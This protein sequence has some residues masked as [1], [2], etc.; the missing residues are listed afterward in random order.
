MGTNASPSV[1]F[2][3]RADTTSAPQEFPLYTAAVAAGFPSAADDYVQER[4]DLNRALIQHPDATYFARASGDSMRDAGIHDGD[5]LVVDCAV[6]PRDGHV[7]VVAIDGELTVKRL[8][9]D[10]GALYLVPA[11]PAYSPIKVSPEADI[12]I[13]GVVTY[14][15][16]K[17]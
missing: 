15:V 3:G 6:D 7:A 1:E 5:I 11:N 9:E 17:V 13:W 12:R 2:L 10:G 16:H 14:A 8:K 4:L